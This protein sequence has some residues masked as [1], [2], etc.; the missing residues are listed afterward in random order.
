[1]IIKYYSSLNERKVLIKSANARGE[2]TIHDDFKDINN[3]NTDGKSG[4]LTFDIISNT[5]N[6]IF[7]RQQELTKKLETKDLTLKELNE[8]V[9]LERGL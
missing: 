9:R 5:V 1:M 8:L 6:P 4:R 2:S 7:E 3:N